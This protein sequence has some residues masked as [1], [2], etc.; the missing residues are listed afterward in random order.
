MKR[1]TAQEIDAI[2]RDYISGLTIHE[3]ATKNSVC[4]PTVYRYTREIERD[5]GK[6]RRY[7][8]G[9]R[10]R[11][12]YSDILDFIVQYKRDNDGISPSIREIAAS[13]DMSQGGTVYALE[14]LIESGEIRKIGTYYSRSICVTGG[15][16]RLTS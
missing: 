10:E 7:V 2:R 1:L 5:A 13:C 15:E 12:D 14:R 4:K 11:I 8:K 9:F 3:I 16:W 6:A